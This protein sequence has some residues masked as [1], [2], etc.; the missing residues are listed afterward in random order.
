MSKHR[1]QSTVHAA[2]VASF[3]VSEGYDF[4]Y[5]HAG[6]QYNFIVEVSDD[7]VAQEDF[8]VFLT[9][10]QLVDLDVKPKETLTGESDS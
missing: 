9:I 5:F 8:D 7:K 1:V 2:T 3:L 10:F 6:D 4:E